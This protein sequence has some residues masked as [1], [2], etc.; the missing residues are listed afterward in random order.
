MVAFCPM[1]DLEMRY[2]TSKASMQE[3]RP[4]LDRALAE[5]FPGGMMKASWQGDV[6]ELSGPGAQ[7]TVV[8]EEGQ[9]VGRATLKPPAALM[10]PVI[11]QKMKH[12]L[13]KAAG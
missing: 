8:Y 7:G 3:I 2:D 4:E 13:Q 6:L 5:S 11:E 12:V 9:L 1:S 10:R